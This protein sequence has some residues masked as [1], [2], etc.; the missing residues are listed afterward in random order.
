MFFIFVMRTELVLIL[1]NKMAGRAGGTGRY[2]FEFLA[3]RA[4][5]TLA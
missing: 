1:W 4:R 5:N 3:S 2:V